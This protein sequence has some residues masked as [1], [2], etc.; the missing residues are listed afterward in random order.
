V[1]NLAGEDASLLVIL[2]GTP[3]LEAHLGKADATFW[4]RNEI[5]PLGRLSLDEAREALTASLQEG[6]I[7]VKA[8]SAPGPGL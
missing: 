1:Q 4:D 5:L 8:G 7:K 2:A 6:K 3:D